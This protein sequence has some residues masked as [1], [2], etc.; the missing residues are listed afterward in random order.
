[1][2]FHSRT[3]RTLGIAFAATL[4]SQA[5]AMAQAMKNTPGQ[6]PQGS[7][8][9]NSATEN[10]DFADAD[11]DGDFDAIMADGGD[12]CND[13]NRIWINLGGAQA[14]TMGFFVSLARCAAHAAA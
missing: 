5:P 9:N 7:P 3:R 11:L 8:F 10:V 4:A 6:I 1:M 13:Q 14:G 12:C 2:H